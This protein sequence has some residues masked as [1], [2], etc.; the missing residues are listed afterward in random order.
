VLLL[1]LEPQ[2]GQRQVYIAVA[3][4]LVLDVLAVRRRAMDRAWQM[5]GGKETGFQL[6]FTEPRADSG[7]LSPAALALIR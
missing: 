3:A 1:V 4:Q 7:Q 6:S 5:L 2:M